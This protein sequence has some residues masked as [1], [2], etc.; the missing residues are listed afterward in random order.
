MQGMAALTPPQSVYPRPGGGEA[1]A[2]LPPAIL[3]LLEERRE[4]DARIDELVEAANR[5][6]LA[7]QTELTLQCPALPKR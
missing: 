7:L 3:V 6:T 1:A 5:L 2:G 4:I